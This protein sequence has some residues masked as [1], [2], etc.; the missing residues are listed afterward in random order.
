M[1][2][3]SWSIIGAG[4]LGGYYGARLHHAGIAVRFLLHSDYDHV[5][6]HG[7]RVH[8]K[9]GDFSIPV[10]DAYRNASD[11]PR[12]DVVAVCLKTTKNGLLPTLLP[13]AVRDDS[14]ILMMQNG[15][16]IEADAAAVLPRHTIVGGLAFLC[17]N[18]LGPGDIHH[19][20]Y[21]A[22]RLGEH[23]RGGENGGI[24][25]A[26]TAIGKDLEDSGI[27]V[28]MEADLALAR[29]KKLVWNVPYNGLCVVEA[30]T[31]DVLMSERVTRDRCERIMHEVLAIAAACGKP[32]HASFADAMLRDTARMV[33][34]KPSMLLDFERGNELE[35]DAI[36]AR[37]LAAA[38]AHEV[39][40]PQIEALYAQ[41]LALAPRKQRR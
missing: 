17:S 25:A 29:W 2:R 39:A 21:G 7:L 27:P 20:D 5:K 6:R 31:T 33:A 10:P 40:C 16:D 28:T 38:R 19:L 18:K 36:Y 24:T 13:A 4:A 41:L 8:S 32:I 23:R 9:D 34:Y 37:P 14:T 11:L 15:L 1:T 30:C 26:M 35:T 3:R 22:V 12:S